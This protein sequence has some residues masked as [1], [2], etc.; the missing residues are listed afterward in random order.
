MTFELLQ[1]CNHAINAQD[2]AAAVQ[3]LQHLQLDLSWQRS[4]LPSFQPLYSGGPAFNMASVCEEYVSARNLQPVQMVLTGPPCSGKTALGQH[5]AAAYGVLLIGTPQILA[6]ADKCQLSA[7]DSSTV[8]AAA[9]SG[10]LEGLSAALL[11][12]LCRAALS[13]VAVRNHGY[14][15]DGYPQTLLQAR[16]LF[17]DPREWTETELADRQELAQILELAAGSS[18]AASGATAKGAKLL[19]GAKPGKA[20]AAPTSTRLTTAVENVPDPRQLLSKL[21]PNAVVRLDLKI[22]AM[23]CTACHT[24][25]P[26]QLLNVTRLSLHDVVWRARCAH[27]CR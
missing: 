19:K 15:L 2:A 1:L 18:A 9:A 4:E 3:N 5:L 14:I 25:T 10:S 22:V 11:A 21:M 27:M 26:V 7:G 16:E 13:T 8:K 12:R 6:A 20:D 23:T 17:T 24:S